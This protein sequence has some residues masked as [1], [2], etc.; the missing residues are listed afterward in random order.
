[1]TQH[2]SL[3]LQRSARDKAGFRKK[4]CCFTK[5]QQQYIHNEVYSNHKFSDSKVGD[6]KEIIFQVISTTLCFQVIHSEQDSPATQS[7][8]LTSNSILWSFMSTCYSVIAS[9]I[10]EL[11][12]ENNFFP[13]IPLPQW[14]E[15]T[16]LQNQI[17]L[18]RS[19]TL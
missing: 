4:C 7:P 12:S 5:Q 15:W 9:T 11:G 17:C 8:R 2:S 6:N 13:E 10:S 19:C 3:Q 14:V 18:W 1:M 16:Q